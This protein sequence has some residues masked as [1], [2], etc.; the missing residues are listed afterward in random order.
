MNSA[1]IYIIQGKAPG[2]SSY[3]AMDLGEGL[4]V[5]KLL[6]ATLLTEAEADYAL[7]QLRT[8]EPAWNWK[9][10]KKGKENESI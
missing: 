8:A 9:K 2:Q 6:Y 1:R 10:L 7:S 3:K 4:Q 5:S